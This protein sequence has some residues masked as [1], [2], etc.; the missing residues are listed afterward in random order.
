MSDANKTM[1]SHQHLVGDL[2][3]A[4]KQ[5]WRDVSGMSGALVR[6]CVVYQMRPEWGLPSLV[7]TLA[8]HVWSC[9]IMQARLQ[10]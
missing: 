4:V 3:T 1:K 5:A 2:V 8:E 7:E 6:S 10:S 9:W